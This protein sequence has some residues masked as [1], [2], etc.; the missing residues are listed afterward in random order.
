MRF[1]YL[2]TMI[3]TM[4]FFFSIT[5]ANAKNE[6]STSKLPLISSGSIALFD[7]RS[8]QLHKV[9]EVSGVK[10]LGCEKMKN[11]KAIEV[12]KKPI[13]AI[14]DSRFNGNPASQFCAELGG[15]NF[16][17]Y[18]SSKNEVNICELDDKSMFFSWDVYYR[19]YPNSMI[20]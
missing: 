12:A 19:A 9:S 13:K 20:K 4:A 6:N 18:N 2:N 7:G 16:I 11:C 10:V 3:S 15:K 14:T 17:G 5:N 8:Y 1:R